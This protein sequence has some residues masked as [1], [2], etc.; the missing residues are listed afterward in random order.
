MEQV[1]LNPEHY[2]RYPHEFSGGQRQRIGVAR[3]IA[4][5]PELIVADEPVSA[6]DVSIQAQVINL[7]RDLQ[8]ELGLTI[9]F[10]AH[11]LSRRAAHVRPHRGDVPRED[12][13]ARR[14]PTSCSTTRA[15][16]TRAR[17]SARCRSPTRA[18]PA[19]ARAPGA[20][21]RRPVADRAAPGVPLPH[22]LPEGAGRLLGRGAAAR[23]EG[24]RQRGRMPLPA[25]RRRGRRR[26]FRRAPPSAAQ[27]CVF[28]A[29]FFGGA[30]AVGASSR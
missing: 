17:C 13:R 26:A 10:I 9:V 25:G 11:D 14:P 27:R 3:A 6:L 21:R 5:K 18:G 8:R 16:P 4:L 24:R 23:A 7:L 1:G 2:N 15:I 12:R 20:R 22:P 19:A 29:F 30:G 28:L